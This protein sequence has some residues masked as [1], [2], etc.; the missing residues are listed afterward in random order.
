MRGQMSVTHPRFSRIGLI[1]EAVL[2]DP[3]IGFPLDQNRCE[4]IAWLDAQGILYSYEIHDRCRP[5]SFARP[6]PQI[7]YL[8]TLCIPEDAAAFW[9]RMTLNVKPLPDGFADRD[10]DTLHDYFL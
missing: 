5:D 7:D 9:F 2:G 8:I 4:R 10:Y 1:R 6:R 3:D